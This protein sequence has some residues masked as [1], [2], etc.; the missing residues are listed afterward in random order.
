MFMLLTF[1]GDFS[2]STISPHPTLLLPAPEQTFLLGVVPPHLALYGNVLFSLGRS[3]QF[4]RK[5]EH[6]YVGFHWTETSVQRLL[7]IY[8]GFGFRLKVGEK[9]LNALT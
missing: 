3:G 7:L 6:T 9:R 8:I 2:P 5:Q 1:T 4:M